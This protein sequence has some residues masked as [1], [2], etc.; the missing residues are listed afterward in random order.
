V[1]TVLPFDLDLDGDDAIVG[2]VIPTL[3][4]SPS[5]MLMMLPMERR[6]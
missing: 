1:S 6:W 4:V 5:S 2:D 3:T